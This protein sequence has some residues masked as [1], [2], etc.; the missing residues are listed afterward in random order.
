M[1]EQLLALWAAPCPISPTTKPPPS[2]LLAAGYL[3]FRVGAPFTHFLQVSSF[4]HLKKG[5]FLPIYLLPL[6]KFSRHYKTFFL[7]YSDYLTA[8][9]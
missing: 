1:Q 7:Y 8:M 9:F 2:G 6:S 5:L 3:C 4:L